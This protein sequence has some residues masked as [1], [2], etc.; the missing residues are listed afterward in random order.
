[1]KTDKQKTLELL[2]KAGEIWKPIK[3]FEGFY[4]VSNSGVVKSL[5]RIIER[6]NKWPYPVVERV[7][8]Q[9]PSAKGYLIVG[10]YKDK[11]QTKKSVHVLVAESFIPN[12]QNKPQVNHLDC[13]K[14]NNS[15]KN[16]EWCTNEENFEHARKNN[17]LPTGERCGNSKLTR[18]QVIEIRKRHT[19]NIY[20]ATLALAKEFGISA[21]NIRGIVKRDT[22]RH[23]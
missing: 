1:M 4:E 9:T 17:L 12:P 11:A 10:L 5:P 16:L 13:N 20:G 23:I 15:V 7:L 14:K 2:Q 8:S 3:G 18:K 19:P 22:W 21:D 6:R